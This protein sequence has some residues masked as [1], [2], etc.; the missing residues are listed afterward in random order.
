[1]SMK[2]FDSGRCPNGLVTVD[3]VCLK[4]EK[5]IDPLDNK[6]SLAKGTVMYVDYVPYTNSSQAFFLKNLKFA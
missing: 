5:I 6:E 1:M 4:P 3:N 2:K